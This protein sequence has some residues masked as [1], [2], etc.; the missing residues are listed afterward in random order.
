MRVRLG[1]ERLIA[2]GQLKN[3]RV[4]VVSNPASIDA[5]YTHVTRTIG[6]ASGVTLGA[7]F[8]PQHG[9]RADV[10]DNMIETGHAHDPTRGV[11]VYSLYSETRE[12]TAEMLKGLDA[13]VIDL[14]DVGSRIYTFIYTMANCL[15]ACKRHGVPVFVTD[16]PNP[17][18]GTAVAG[19]TLVTGFESFVGQFPIPMQHGMTI[20]ELAGYFNEVFEIG[21]ALT[22]VPMEG[23]TRGMFYEDT[24]LPWVMPSPNIPTVDSAIVYP[25]TVLFEGTN[26]SEGRGTTRP[27]E[28]IGAPWVDAEALADRL[29]A[30]GLPGVHFR[31]VVFEPTFQKHAKRACGGCQIHVLSRSDFRAVEAGVA[32]LIEIRGQNPASFQW[33]QPPYEYEHEK[34]PFDILAGSPQTREQIDAGTPAAAIYDSWTSGVE[35]FRAAR[36]PYLM[37]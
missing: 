24:G 10:Q 18:G 13:L 6:A 11:P 33:R 29:N 17:V 1:S 23:W 14:Q 20:A 3:M 31:P 8:G 19:P 28:L 9:F 30:R 4:G 16:R 21:A 34:L 15:R 7:I 32:V 35:Q 5:S 22:L 2:S 12:P 36:K 25:G 26:V 27:F 37:Y